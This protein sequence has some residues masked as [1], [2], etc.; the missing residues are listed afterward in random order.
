[1]ARQELLARLARCD[2]GPVVSIRQE[3]LC[4]LDG[5][6]GWSQPESA[7]APGP[8]SEHGYAGLLHILWRSQRERPLWLRRRRFQSY[9]LGRVFLGKR[10]AVV[11]ASDIAIYAEGSAGPVGSAE[12]CVMLIGRNA[13]VGFERECH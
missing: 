8:A 9:R 10:N 12:V 5:I 6:A 7:R 4:I 3:S 11:F 2:I 13:P 1:M